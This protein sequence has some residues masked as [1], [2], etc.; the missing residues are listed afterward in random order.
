MFKTPKRPQ[1]WWL[2]CTS[3]APCLAPIAFSSPR[4]AGYE[5]TRDEIATPLYELPI[6]RTGRSR[7]PTPETPPSS[8]NNGEH[9]ILRGLRLGLFFIRIEGKCRERDPEFGTTVLARSRPD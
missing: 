3:A 5:C 6:A 4:R 7:R 2:A 8:Q 9:L 1:T